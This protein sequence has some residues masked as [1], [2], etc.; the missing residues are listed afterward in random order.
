MG[1]VNKKRSTFPKLAIV[2][3]AIWVALYAF[4]RPILDALQLS[5]F[6][7]SVVSSALGVFA[8]CA[9]A[10][11]AEAFVFEAVRGL[12]PARRL[13]A[14]GLA[15]VVVVW[16]IVGPLLLMDGTLATRG[17]DASPVLVAILAGVWYFA[18]AL[19]GFLF[20]ALDLTAS[21]VLRTF[22]ERTRALAIA[23]LCLTCALTIFAAPRFVALLRIADSGGLSGWNGV[24]LDRALG[25]RLAATPVLESLLAG[26]SAHL[27]FRLAL[28]AIAVL[29][30]VLS[31]TRKFVEGV[32]ERIDPLIVALD[33]VASGGRE[34]LVAEGGSEEFDRLGKHFNHMVGRLGMAE[35]MER[36]FGRYASMHLLDRIRAQHGEADLPAGMRDA[37]VLFA[38]IR[39]FTTLSE[40]LAPEHVVA[41][42]NRFFASATQVIDEHEGFLN[43]FVGDAI[44]VVF[45]GPVDQGDHAERATRCAVQ[46]QRAVA[47]LNADRAFEYVER[48]EVGIGIASGPMICGNVGGPRHTEYTVIGDVVNTASRLCG[49]APGGEV[50]VT[51]RTADA[52]PAA[53]AT[54]PLPAL[55]VKGKAAPVEAACA[56]PLVPTLLDESTLKQLQA[57][58]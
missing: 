39:G 2:G 18:A 37:S 26:H 45:N 35:R 21:A 16:V 33:A 20:V 14:L 54:T 29:P 7:F 44:M 46:L 43:K 15:P 17:R 30:A 13:L 8:A 49:A 51:K 25:S 34:V 55:H 40:R 9:I 31:A 27:L 3:L 5:P 11:W 56:W 48:I 23:L 6:T 50:W 47:Q 12:A 1:T 53:L 22:R 32:M 28:L 42:L 58:N 38:D 36:A 19:G 10:S 4:N 24:A 41:V 52:L 57:L